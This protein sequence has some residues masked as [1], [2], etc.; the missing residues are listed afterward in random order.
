MDRKRCTMLSVYDS[1]VLAVKNIPIYSS[2]V[3]CTKTSNPSSVGF[4][5]DFRFE[6]KIKAIFGE[7]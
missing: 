2:N 4:G 7:S 6:K 1:F 3:R 5:S